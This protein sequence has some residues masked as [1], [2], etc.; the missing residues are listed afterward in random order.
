M[1]EITLARDPESAFGWSL[2]RIRAA[3]PDFTVKSITASSALEGY[4][5]ENLTDQDPGTTRAEDEAG[6]GE[7]FKGT[8]HPLRVRLPQ[9]HVSL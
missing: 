1:Y 6:Y 3:E 5:T 9:E 2:S 7:T 8:R 4:L